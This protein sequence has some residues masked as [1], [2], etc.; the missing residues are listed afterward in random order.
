MT[1]L[2]I[3]LRVIRTLLM[4][5]SLAWYVQ[6]VP[7]QKETI[8]KDSCYAV[9]VLRK[10]TVDGCGHYEYKTNLC[11]SN[12]MP[13]TFGGIKNI[14]KPCRPYL[15]VIKPIHILCRRSGLLRRKYIK[16]ILICKSTATE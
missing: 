2:Q 1:N 15:S 4:L 12:C 10:A 14:C 7:L 11:H 8:T 5:S 16:Q 9:P 13:I 3:M 6:T